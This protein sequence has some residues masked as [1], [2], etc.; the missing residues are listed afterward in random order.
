MFNLLQLQFDRSTYWWRRGEIEIGHAVSVIGAK[1]LPPGV[2]DSSTIELDCDQELKIDP[3]PGHRNQYKITLSLKW[4]PPELVHG[5]NQY[6]VYISD[7][8]TVDINNPH[9]EI[10]IVS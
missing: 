5:G 10:V 3:V 2:I 9:K 6:E 4:S 8:T 7:K 1:A